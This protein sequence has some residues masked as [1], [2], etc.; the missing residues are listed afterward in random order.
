MTTITHALQQLFASSP[1]AMLVYDRQSFRLLAFNDGVA[2]M[3]GWSTERLAGMDVTALRENPDPADL[4]RILD[5][6][7][8]TFARVRSRHRRAD[9]TA[10]WVTVSAL[11]VDWDGRPAQ[12]NLIEDI[13]ELVE[14]ET[15]D[16]EA[17]AAARAVLEAAPE[18]VV[19]TDVDGRILYA[20][21]AAG[22][23][24]RCPLDQLRGEHVSLLMPDMTALP[25]AVHAERL[26]A[27][28]TGDLTCRR[29]DGTTFPAELSLTETTVGDRVRYTGILRDV[30]EQRAQAEAL[31]WAA[32]HDPL[33]GLANRSRVAA[34]L[35]RALAH[36][37]PVV[38]MV[39]LD[40]FRVVNDAIG[41]L[42]AD[43]VLEEM[44]RR[45][46]A[47]SG[48]DSLVGRLGGNQYVVVAPAADLPQGRA[49]AD[50]IAAAIARPILAEGTQL[51]LT[52]SIGLARAGAGA[53]AASDLLREAEAAL[54]RAKARGPGH[55]HAATEML[56]GQLAARVQRTAELGRGIGADELVAHYQPEFHIPSGR[57]EGFEALVRWQHPTEGLLTP[58]AFVP[59]AEESGL[60]IPLGDWIVREAARQAARWNG[61][62]ADPLR[63][64]V[65][66]SARQVLDQRMK[67]LVLDAIAAGG[68]HGRWLGLE[69]TE[70]VLAE[71][72]VIDVGIL[73]ELR[74][75]GLA[76]AVDD[77]GTGYSSLSYLARFPVD[78]V[79]LD[80]SFIVD[81]PTDRRV[82]AIVRSTITMAHDLGMSVV[83]EGIETAAQLDQLRELGC[84]T[85]Q[86]Y[87]LGR[88]QPAEQIGWPEAARAT[89]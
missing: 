56:R 88:P 47:A 4:R 10:F 71:D 11:Q 25:L 35:T 2:R 39:D 6:I 84:D 16:S 77:F 75:E 49:L 8:G 52:A 44:G 59:L 7:Q 38:I 66:L 3:Y 15:A 69:I 29:F 23:I 18:A 79:K 81:L 74:A 36:H 42:A 34:E 86:G 76:F 80:R 27:H 54:M 28:G 48:P 33:T 32:E 37:R 73:E 43:A 82:R 21:P 65:N 87:L 9:G 45:L 31:R 53:V 78:A 20:N 70:S 12:L 58:G 22:R 46:S 51:A 72:G 41:H 13:T 83:A 89:G 68:A 40:R 61:G 55:I 17:Q 50:G 14:R 60:I 67:G 85:A 1:V 24:F 64:W 57:L 63:V 5:A 19:T 26:T 30:S 62:R